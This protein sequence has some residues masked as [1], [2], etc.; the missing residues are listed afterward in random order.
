MHRDFAEVSVHAIDTGFSRVT[1][2]TQNYEPN[3]D[4]ECKESSLSICGIETISKQAT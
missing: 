3:S 2:T 4:A 1:A